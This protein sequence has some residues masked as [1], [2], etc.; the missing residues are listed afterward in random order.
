[1]QG[2]TERRGCCIQDVEGLVTVYSPLKAPETVKQFEE[3]YAMMKSSE[4]S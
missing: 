1:M 3:V 4:S 2:R